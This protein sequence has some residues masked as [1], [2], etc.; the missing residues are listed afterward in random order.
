MEG[1]DATD[2]FA[3]NTVLGA[4]IEVQ[5]VEALNRMR[6]V[7]DPSGEWPLHSFVRQAQT[8]PDVLLRRRSDDGADDIAM[9]IELKGWYLLAKEAVPSFRYT[10][11]PTACTDWDLLAVVPWCLS[12][13]VSGRPEVR[14]PGIWPARY[15]AE[16]RNYWWQHVRDARSETTIEMPDGVEPYLGRDHTVDRPV[17]DGGSNFG[18]IARIGI[19]DSWIKDA[20]RQPLAGIPAQDWSAFLRRHSDDSNP[21]EVFSILSSEAAEALVQRNT[22]R[23]DEVLATL[24]RLT[25]LLASD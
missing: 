15:V 19:M 23:A 9:G 25:A 1:L 16:Y 4:T 17:S 21:D 24:R 3:L 14:S 5:V 8:F 20:M 2:L 18:R 7:W 10:V 13:V 11:T 6:E 22:A 12:N